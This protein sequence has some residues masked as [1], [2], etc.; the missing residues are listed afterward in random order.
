VAVEAGVSRCSGR[1]PRLRSSHAVW[2]THAIVIVTHT[3]D[4]QAWAS[5]RTN[6]SM[7]IPPGRYAL[8]VTYTVSPDWRNFV[9]DLWTGS[10]E[11]VP[12]P[13]TIT[14]AIPGDRC[15]IAPEPFNNE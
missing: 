11:A 8:G 4:L 10:I 12:V 2:L 9:D 5:R 15:A 1:G 14:G 7:R 6:G 3:L 13:V